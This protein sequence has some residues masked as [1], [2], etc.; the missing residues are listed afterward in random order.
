MTRVLDR[1][2]AERGKPDGL[3]LDNGP[4]F[5]SRYFTAW[6]EQRG[7]PLIYIQPGKPV[8]N[9]YIES[10]DGRFRDECLNANALAAVH[11][12]AAHPQSGIG[13]LG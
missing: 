10:F 8:Q 9:R 2:I 13:S 5:T 3:R 4:E 11:F 6:A 7:V 1:I 12:S